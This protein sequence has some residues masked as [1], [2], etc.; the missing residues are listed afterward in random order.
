MPTALQSG[1]SNTFN[2]F[3]GSDLFQLNFSA[4]MSIPSALGTTLVVNGGGLLT[5]NDRVNVNANQGGD[6]PRTVQINYQSGNAAVVQGLG[7]PAGIQVN[8]TRQVNYYGDA[9]NNDQL[10]VT[11]PTSGAHTLSVTP[12]SAHSADL[13]LDGTPLLAG[14]ATAANNPGVAGGGLGPDLFVDGVIQNQL[15]VVGGSSGPGVVNKL[16]VN[17]PDGRSQRRRRNVGLGRQYFRRLAVTSGDRQR[18]QHDHR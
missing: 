8:G 2:G 5:G 16:I 13:F 14:T 6:G 10:Q 18:L 17:A 3:D 11:T 7:T 12:I 15:H 1:A 9:A 4:G